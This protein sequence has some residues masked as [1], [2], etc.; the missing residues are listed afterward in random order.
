MRWG[1]FRRSD[2]VEDVGRG[3]GGGFG[4]PVRLSGG[5]IIVAVIASLLFGVNPLDMLGGMMGA[6]PQVQA[7]APSRS[8]Q[9][10]PA[11]APKGS[12]RDFVAAVLGSTEDVWKEVF[13][14]MGS[15]YDP[16]KLATF[17]AAVQSACGRASTAAGP[18]YCPA[19][20]KVYL[21]LAFF[22]ELERRFKAPGDFAQGYV[23][24]HEVGHHVQNLLGIMDQFTR[25]QQRGDERSRNALSIRLELQADCFA[26]IWG[27]YVQGIQK[28]DPGD[29]EEGLN[30]ASAVGD[31][32]IQKRTRGS[33]VPDAFTH[34][35]ATQRVQWFRTGFE[36]GDI[37]AC[38]TFNTRA[39]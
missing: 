20:R 16:P 33:V 11:P 28:L 25:E 30:A 9:P 37:R 8:G 23:I 12:Q 26:G 32:T 21:D 2:N 6:G 34:G 24:A 5:A 17:E 19:D 38:N 1:D 29:L 27:H 4:G 13:R 39:P 31:D 14:K 10:P 15:Q 7:P 22:A 35:S 18:F 3:G 36:S